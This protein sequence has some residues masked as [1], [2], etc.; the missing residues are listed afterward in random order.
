MGWETL[1]SEQE[2]RNKIK[3]FVDDE[4]LG[5]AHYGL[6]LGNIHE[7][8]EKLNHDMRLRVQSLEWVLDEYDFEKEKCSCCHQEMNLIKRER[9]EERKRITIKIPRFLRKLLP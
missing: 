8:W 7:A 6:P 1:K 2:I 4:R 9:E 3:E 5:E